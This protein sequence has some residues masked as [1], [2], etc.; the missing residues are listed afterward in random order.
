MKASIK[1]K[2][3]HAFKALEKMAKPYYI[4]ASPMAAANIRKKKI[5]ALLDSGAKVV[6]MTANLI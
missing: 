4:A 6:V 3:K 1:N 2:E 5:S